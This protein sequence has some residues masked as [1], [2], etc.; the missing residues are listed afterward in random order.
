MKQENIVA[1]NLRLPEK[2]KIAITKKAK[3]EKRSLNQH[4][5][6]LLEKYVQS[7][8]EKQEK[9]LAVQS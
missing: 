1:Y 7:D 6:L 5:V 4:I 3:K 9:S 2:L 8:S